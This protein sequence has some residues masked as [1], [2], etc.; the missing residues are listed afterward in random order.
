MMLLMGI[1]M[2]L[3]KNPMKPI[4]ENPIAVAIAIFWNSLRSGFVHL[5]TRRNES[6]ANSFAGSKAAVIWS[7]FWIS[8]SIPLEKK[9]NL[10]KTEQRKMKT[11][12]QSYDTSCLYILE[13]RFWSQIRRHEL[14]NALIHVC[15]SRM[16][17]HRLVDLSTR[18]RPNKNCTSDE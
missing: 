7:I 2:S 5:F 3:T 4:I 13:Y 11:K 17:K 1:W 14:L 9:S 18:A 6:F 16:L 12:N 8:I 15:T 10:S